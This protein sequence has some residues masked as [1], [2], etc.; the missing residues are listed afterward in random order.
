MADFVADSASDLAKYGLDHPSLQIKLA[1]YAS[2]NT[3]ESNA[4]EK[5]ITTVSF[6]KSDDALAYACV[7]GEPFVVSVPKSLLEELPTDPDA[8]QSDT[9]FQNDPARINALEVAVSGRPTL[10]LNHPDKGEW[11]LTG[12][13]AGAL[14]K[15][16][17]ESI[18]NT[19]TR[20]HA[21]RWLG[22]VKPEYRF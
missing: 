1:S 18:V 2:G 14:S 9:I 16:K 19:L 13:T 22:A 21:V 10:A 8:W 4:G 15:P 20:L 11:T 5:P 6:G 17:A 7:E 3:A 12:K